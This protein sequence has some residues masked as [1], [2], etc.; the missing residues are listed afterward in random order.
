MILTAFPAQGQ[1]QGHAQAQEYGRVRYYNNYNRRHN[2][3]TP[4]QK[5]INWLPEEETPRHFTIA[6]R[7]I[8][9]ISYGLK[10]DF[11]FEFLTGKWLQ[12]SLAGYYAPQYDHSMV[13]GDYHF[14]AQSGGWKS[15]MSDG[16]YF[17]KLG[18]GGLAV[19]YKSMFSNSGWYWS[20]EM[21]FYYYDVSHW[22]N[23]YYG[24]DYDMRSY[25]AKKYGKTVRMQFYKPGINI[26]IGKHF[27]LGRNL[28]LDAYIGLGYDFT[29]GGREIPEL[30]GTKYYVYLFER[31]MF[32]F[33]YRALYINSGLRLGWVWP[34]RK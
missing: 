32:A 8:Q 26:N 25:V 1:A 14:S 10:V 17:E 33:G 16:E 9:L 20:A 24:Y 11:E 34:N 18:G 21:H 2:D 5:P 3:K 22:L 6:V 12:F 15:P 19:A 4:A 29:S 13:S 28:F 30:A 27:A 7:P 23:Y 31:G